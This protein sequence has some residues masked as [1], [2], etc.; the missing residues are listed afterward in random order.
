MVFS[1]IISLLS[2]T[3]MT[4]L[5]ATFCDGPTGPQG[6]AY[7]SLHSLSFQ[8]LAFLCAFPRAWLLLSV[9]SV[10]VMSSSG[11]VCFIYLFFSVLKCPQEFFYY[12]YI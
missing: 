5:P 10:W 3:M 9:P 4:G 7:L 2:G 12:T 8:V 1:S 6:S 11:E